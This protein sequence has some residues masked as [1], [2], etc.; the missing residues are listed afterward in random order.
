MFDELRGIKSD[1]K[2][3][4]EFGLT[5]GMVFLAL[6]GFAAWRSGPA[7]PYLL[8]A[9]AAFAALAFIIPAV[10]KPLQKLWMGLGIV[11]GF[12]VSRIILSVLFYGVMTPIGI[13][14]KLL[15]KDILDE[16]ID[17]TAVSYW[18]TR[19]TAVKPKESYENQY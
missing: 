18:H 13:V 14:M 7:W 15:G 1:K 2:N 8:T 9:G 19:D 4:R 6:G 3:L 16:R 17:K 12:F 5:M 11:L 10:L